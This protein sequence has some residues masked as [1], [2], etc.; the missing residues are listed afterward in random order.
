MAPK[1]SDVMEM[2]VI[3]RYGLII[4][5]YLPIVT[6]FC[7]LFVFVVSVSIMENYLSAEDHI[8]PALHSFK[9]KLLIFDFVVN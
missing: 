4:R 2:C 5:G 1:A 3:F 7:Y 8:L 9:L 6:N